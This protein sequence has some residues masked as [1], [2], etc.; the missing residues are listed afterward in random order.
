MSRNSK[1]D[2]VKTV[3]IFLVIL[4]H[5]IQSREGANVLVKTFVYSFHMPLFIMIS[6]YF[7][8]VSCSKSDMLRRCLEIFA[9]FLVFQLIRLFLSRDF[10]MDTCLIPRYTLWY[11]LCLVFWRMFYYYTSKKFSIGGIL[12]ISVAISLLSGFISTNLFS[13][14]RACSFLPF[15]VLGGW[16]RLKNGFDAVDKR[17]INICLFLI[18]PIVI[19]ALLKFLCGVN[20][21]SLYKGNVAY[22]TPLG[23]VYRLIWLV[24]SSIISVCVYRIIPDKQTLAKY[25]ASTLVVYLLHSFFTRQLNYF[26]SGIAF[27]NL[28]FYVLFSIL[29][30]GV[31]VCLGKYKIIQLLIKPIRMK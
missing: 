16:L 19:Y 9:T 26:P 28:L 25:G 30:F 6:G 2:S 1:L 7:C 14:Q 12:V 17:E 24:L 3:L 4:G 10:T 27:N 31:C 20:L 29:V 11:L 13:F 8:N 22:S 18:V 15:F 5:A 21:M 23:S